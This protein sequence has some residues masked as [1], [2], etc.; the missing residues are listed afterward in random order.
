MDYTF[1]FLQTD[2]FCKADDTLLHFISTCGYLLHCSV[3]Q[4]VQVLSFVKFWTWHRTEIIQIFWLFTGVYLYVNVSAADL[5]SGPILESPIFHPPPCYHSDSSQL[6]SNSC[7]VSW[8]KPKH[9]N[10]N[11][12]N[13]ITWLIVMQYQSV[14]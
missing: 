6:Y 11:Y 2:S 5:G 4:K 12:H 3:F 1:W 13:F 10:P 14:F 7:T 9:S 8:K